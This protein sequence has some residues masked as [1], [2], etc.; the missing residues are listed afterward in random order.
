MQWL[1]FSRKRH[2]ELCVL[3]ALL[4]THRCGHR[5]HFVQRTAADAPSRL[6]WSSWLVAAA[7][8]AASN[9]A[10]V[11]RIGFAAL[12]FLIVIPYLASWFIRVATRGLLIS[13]DW[14]SARVSS[15]ED[16]LV[17]W[18]CGGAFVLLVVFAV[19]TTT[20]L[21]KFVA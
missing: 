7:R 18:L 10:S 5:F 20:S 15:V 13:T 12:I 1:T 19:L 4:S 3:C 11:F 21:L 6:A 14:I 16:V 9:S 8:L 2:C 17:D